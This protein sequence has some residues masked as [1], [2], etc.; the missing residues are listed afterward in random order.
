M[1]QSEIE[2][3][4][5]EIERSITVPVVRRQGFE[6]YHVE[7]DQLLIL[8][9]ER[10]TE[11]LLP[12]D[13][14]S[15]NYPLTWRYLQAHREALERR[16]RGRFRDTWWCLSRAQ[17]IRRWTGAKVLV[18]YM[19]QRLQAVADLT[20]RFFVNVTTGGYGLSVKPSVAA[21]LGENSNDFLVGLLNSKLLD[22]AMRRLSNHF[23]GGYYPANKQYL[24]HLP[25]KLPLTR[26]ERL[27]AERIKESVRI[28]VDS[29]AALKRSLLSEGEARQLNSRIESNQ[30]RIDVAVLDLYGLSAVPDGQ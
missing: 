12:M 21:I 26:P 1:F 30:K 5:I 18:P 4:S 20:G 13:E 7:R 22:Y 3:T 25:V 10:A 24:Q 23:H 9:Y 27:L 17:N 6:A 28:I 8:P 2:G 11:E 15:R 29:V 14:L 19:I 16:E